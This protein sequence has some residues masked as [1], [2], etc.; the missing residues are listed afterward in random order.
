MNELDNKIRL[1][2]LALSEAVR[3]MQ[4]KLDVKDKELEELK[5]KTIFDQL[6]VKNTLDAKDK[7]IE[8]LRK[9]INAISSDIAVFIEEPGLE[10]YDA[11]LKAYK[12]IDTDGNPTPILAGRVE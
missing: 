4:A 6:A 9:C 11:T 1:T 12:L 8:A 10:W 3:V 7:E 2:E 5:V